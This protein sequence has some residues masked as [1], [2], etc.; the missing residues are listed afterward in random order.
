MAF[1][2]FVST[3]LSSNIFEINF[4]EAVSRLIIFS[5]LSSDNNFA[6]HLVPFPQAPETPPSE[7]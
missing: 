5:L 6:T 3:I 2:R 7:L 4:P 1:P